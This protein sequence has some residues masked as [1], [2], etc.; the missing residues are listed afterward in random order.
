MPTASPSVQP[1]SPA[2]FSLGGTDPV[3][4]VAAA[5]LVCGSLGFLA[6]VLR[7]SHLDPGYFD[8][9][10]TADLGTNLDP[11]IT[12]ATKKDTGLAAMPVPRIV[13]A[14]ELEP[15]EFKVVMI[16]Q[17]EALLATKS[18]LFHIKVGSVVPGLGEILAIN[19]VG[20]GGTIKAS[21]ALLQSAAE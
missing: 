15:N 11:M 14:R 9:L 8:R 17:D 12:G 16:F 2:A 7:I 20:R 3:L 4:K 5:L 13:R 19:A 21:K 10:L 18:E 1:K 6:T